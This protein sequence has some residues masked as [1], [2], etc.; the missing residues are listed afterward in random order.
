MRHT[1][2][3]AAK[4][5]QKLI[6]AGFKVFSKKGY[7]TT[8]LTDIA[9]EAGLT[10]GAIYWHFGGKLEIYQALIEEIFANIQK[11]IGEI[12]STELTPLEKIIQLMSDTFV[13]LEKDDI[14]HD[15][16]K[17]ATLKTERSYELKF[18]EKEFSKLKK[19]IFELL[20]TFIIA[21]LSKGEIRSYSSI[22]Y[23]QCLKQF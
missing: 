20:N 12:I 21:A 5:R 17:I 15:I 3:R 13:K 14:F 10:R 23:V 4:T 16:I 8:R 18:I 6:D 9:G 22:V 2:E 1:K 11:F 7:S 19:Y